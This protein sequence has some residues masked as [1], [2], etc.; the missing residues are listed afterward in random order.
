MGYIT[1]FF[2]VLLRI[3]GYPFGVPLIRLLWADSVKLIN[4][5]GIIS[6]NCGKNSE[7]FPYF[8]CMDF[9][10]QNVQKTKENFSKFV[11]KYFEK[12]RKKACKIK[13]YLI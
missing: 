3:S 13:V 10:V 7:V 9:V 1:H 12:N 4:K 6:L 8:V 2:I 11:R 5:H